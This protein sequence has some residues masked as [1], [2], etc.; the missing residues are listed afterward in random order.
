M[1][2]EKSKDGKGIVTQEIGL[3]EKMVKA[4]EARNKINE[5]M[6]THVDVK[7][8]VEGKKWFYNPVVREHFFNPKNLLKTEEEA[9]EYTYEASG[10]GQVGSPACLSGDTLIAVADGRNAV[11][12]RQLA[13]EGKEVDVYS[14]DGEKIIITK[15]TKFRK[16]YSSRKVY[17]VTLDDGTKFKATGDHKVMLRS[18]GYIEV[19][20]LKKNVSLM[21]FNKVIRKGYFYVYDNTGKRRR[22]HEMIFEFNNGAINEFGIEN[23]NIHHIDENK[24]NNKISNLNLMSGEEHSRLHSIKH[25][26]HLK[27]VN[28][29]IKG[30]LNPMRKW[31]NNASSQE[32]ELYRTTMS[33]ATSKEKN[34]RWKQISNEEILRK[35]Y[36]FFILGNRRFTNENW[37]NFAKEND[38]PQCVDPRFNSFNEFKEAVKKNN[39]RVKLIEEA[40]YEDVYNFNVPL[41]NN[42]CIITNSDFGFS[43]VVVKNCGDMMKMWIKIDKEEDKIVECKWQTFGCASAIG[44]TS[45]LSVM[46]TENSGMKIEDALK[47]KPQDIANRL[48]GLPQRKFHCSVLGDKA[49]RYA[50][51][52]YFKKT[53]QNDRVIIDGAKIIDKILK[54]T[55]K[56]IEE[57]VLEGALTLEDVQK[58]TKVGIQDKSC[59]PEVEQLIRFYQEK[60][61]S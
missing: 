3:N 15:G 50:I 9:N 40:G 2:E 33:F 23:P 25:K 45:M 39:H 16:T 58:K 55:D 59:I 29:D 35:T 47:I 41:T 27:R 52:D 30:D 20:K 5:Q 18:G 43:G 19:E 32:K 37:R 44:S 24:L 53:G 7:A 11:S 4:E 54:I 46:L 6:R 48:E 51:N 21:P 28:R 49:L 17:E 61:F 22:E 31:W 8:T 56:D 26:E 60:Y 34:G 42:Y 12:I 36:E 14:Y 10:I 13:K 38:F 1:E 57:A